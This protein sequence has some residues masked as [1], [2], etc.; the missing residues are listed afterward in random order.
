MGK[1]EIQAPTKKPSWPY[2][3]LNNGAPGIDNIPV[4]LLK[5]RGKVI[6]KIHIFMGII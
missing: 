6:N 1:M 5:H 2:R 4:E 3:K